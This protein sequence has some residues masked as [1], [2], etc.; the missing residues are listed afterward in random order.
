MVEDPPDVVLV[1][2]L[3]NPAAHEDTAA[4]NWEQSGGDVD[5]F[6]EFAGTGGT[7]AG[8]ARFLKAQDPSIACYIVEPAGA[9]VLAGEPL[10]E[11]GH[12]IQGGGYSMP[13][14][15]CSTLRWSTGSSRFPTPTR[16]TP[17]DDLRGQRAS[18]PACRRARS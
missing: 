9:A 13:A 17:L 3:G 6:C 15:R 4:E 2:A 11:P 5:V 1:P 18:S 8:M 12:G 10:T 16:S 7:F 14:C